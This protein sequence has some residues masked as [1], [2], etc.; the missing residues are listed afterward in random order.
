MPVIRSTFFG[1][2]V[3][4][5]Q[6]RAGWNQQ[7]S[8]LGVQLVADP[9][10]GDSPSPATIGGPCSFT[11]GGFTFAGLLRRWSET[12]GQDGFPVYEAQIVDPRE[13]LEGAVVITG[14]YNGAVSV[15]NLLNAFGYWE[16][17]AFGAS[18]SGPAGMPWGNVLLA[19]TT[20][21]NTPGGTSY[22]GPLNYKGYNYGLDLSQLPV[23]PSSYRVPAGHAS[24]MDLISQICEDGGCDYFVQLVGTTI[25][26]RTAPRATQP[27]LGTLTT[28]LTS[29]SYSGQTVRSEA[30]TE[31]RNEITSA[32]LVGG[33]K[34][35]VNVTGAI[36]S[37]W[38]TD[39]NGNPVIGVAGV[40]PDLGNCEYMTVKADE[41][42]DILGSRT[43]T[44]N[45]FELR[46]AL[47]NDD[48]WRAYIKKYFANTI[49]ALI[50]ADW[51][52]NIPVE[53]KADAVND[54]PAQLAA[55]VNQ[56]ITNRAARLYDFVR[57]LATDFYGK[58]FLVRLP[59]MLSTTDSETGKVTLS[60]EPT[61][62]G[63]FEGGAE[64]LGISAINQDVIQQPDERVLPFVYYPTIAGAEMTRTSWADSAVDP[65]GS[66]WCRA[67]L[68][69]RVIFI[70]GLPAVPC[71]HFRLT[72]VLYDEALDDHGNMAII[73][74]VM[75]NGNQPLP[76]QNVAKRAFGGTIGGISVHPAAR[77]P[78]AAG[79]PLR[80]NILTYG[81]WYAAGAPG[82]VRY[83]QDPSL[84][85]WDYGGVDVM[86]IAGADRVATA[87]TNTQAVEAGS[88]TVAGI[89][90]YSLGDLLV[91]DG[92][93]LTGIDVRYGTSGV[94]TTYRMETFTPKFYGMG[95]QNA[96][97]LRRSA[98]LAVQ[99]RRD[100]RKALARAFS[101][102]QATDAAFRGFKANKA[103]MKR[104]QSPADVL[105][106][107]AFASSNGDTRVVGGIDKYEAAV[108]FQTASGSL[109]QNK[110]MMSMAGLLR[111]YT[112]N[113]TGT[114]L[115][116]KLTYAAGVTGGTNNPVVSTD[117]NP[118]F[119]GHDIEVLAWG[120][121]YTGAHA[122]RRQPDISNSRPLALRGP[123][124]VAGW[125]PG[126]DGKFYPSGGNT[127][128]SGWLRKSQDWKV[129]PMDALWDNKRGVWT[130]HDVITA[131][132][133]GGFALNPSGTLNVLVGGDASWTIPVYNPWSRAINPNTTIVAAYAFNMHKF[134]VIAADC[135]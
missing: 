56:T 71:A 42:A 4:D 60:H 47:H 51:V 41:V 22:G 94:T 97:R 12:R 52:K 110:G 124:M 102:A 112:T 80:S 40:H 37:Y 74:P 111:P 125:G 87:L 99:F 2:T 66:L 129:G 128:E 17:Q 105:M 126:V 98:L 83:E 62:A 31:A 38:G 64:A 119:S 14:D 91:S 90:Q 65:N 46:F 8:E 30:G 96:E 53:C 1:L 54:D 39:I 120:S 43:Y 29:S 103:L 135:Q 55:M 89:P 108:L 68:N 44:T 34:T 33:A 3:R 109:F 23:P 11:V 116:P 78:T 134:V 16:A 70:P 117:L 28:L 127:Y 93:N 107:E 130:S 59:F 81:P 63:W 24:L 72:S 123:L 49:G 20:M 45:T 118:F 5:I 115:I 27:P 69:P 67:I 15:P 92:P 95:R 6:A 85:P 106:V 77:Y 121:Q 132:I 82:R 21:A 76:A 57:R 48:S 100:V 101:A 36:A 10:N 73:N 9:T 113:P 25:T 84:T 122:Y 131:K 7:G 58:E 18:G 133:P 79:V 35:T 13:I 104:K 75:A 114:G 26:V 19:V 61:D 32:F 86:N 50:F 88:I